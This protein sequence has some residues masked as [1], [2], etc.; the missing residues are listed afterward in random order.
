MQVNVSHVI[1][2]ILVHT[3]R[4]FFFIRQKSKKK[5]DGSLFHQFFHRFIV[6]PFCSSFNVIQLIDR[7]SF[8]LPRI[9]FCV[10]DRNG[11]WNLS[12]CHFPPAGLPRRDGPQPEESQSVPDV[13][14]SQRTR[15]SSSSRQ[16]VAPPTRIAIHGTSTSPSPLNPFQL[17]LVEWD[18]LIFDHFSNETGK[19]F[20]DSWRF[21]GI[22]EGSLKDLEDFFYS[23]GFFWGF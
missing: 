21:D 17:N 1:R 11:R 7:L 5:K 8:V 14:S 16:Y 2:H 20:C 15:R 6:F 13:P 23:M 3:T 19:V 12:L 10:T 18:R 4:L 22:S 9:R